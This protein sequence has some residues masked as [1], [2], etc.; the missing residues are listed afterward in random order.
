M[1]VT[2]N[3]KMRKDGNALLKL[4]KLF[5][6]FPESKRNQRIRPVQGNDSRAFHTIPELLI[7]LFDIFFPEEVRNA[8]DP[9]T[10][11]GRA[12]DAAEDVR[13]SE[14]EQAKAAGRKRCRKKARP[15]PV[16]GVGGGTSTTADV[17]EYRQRRT[18]TM[19]RGAAASTGASAAADATAPAAEQGYDAGADDDEDA[20]AEESG[21]GVVYVLPE[22]AKVGGLLTAIDVWKKSIDYQTAAHAKLRDPDS[23][24]ELRAYAKRGQA[25]GRAWATAVQ[26]HCHQAAPW[27][28]VHRAFAHFEEDVME[29]GHRDTVDDSLLE[30]GNR[31]IKEHKGNVFQGG[32]NEE[33]FVEQTHHHQD[34]NGLWH[35]TKSKK[36]RLPKAIA[37]Q[38]H[39]RTHAAQWFAED[40]PRPQEVTARRKQALQVKHEATGG[41]RT[42]TEAAIHEYQK[43]KLELDPG[44]GTS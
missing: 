6:R 41:K 13:E 28:Y 19:A 14:A 9:L 32:T 5:W 36:R 12:A 37:T 25:A 4:Y 42:A 27:Q 17:H 26:R 24:E 29:N 35:E 33:V 18:A 7:G 22:D 15:P 40:R 10:A 8:H 3:E 1:A 16:V 20:D 21:G 44:A 38:A 39:I 23:I 11:V 31:S 2:F 34:E 43:Q 30:K